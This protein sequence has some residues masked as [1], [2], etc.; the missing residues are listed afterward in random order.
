[1]K[2]NG[3][4]VVTLVFWV[5]LVSSPYNAEG[6]FFCFSRLTD[7]EDKIAALQS[8]CPGGA[9]N[10]SQHRSSVQGN[11]LLFF[12]VYFGCRSD[13]SDCR[14]ELRNFKCNTTKAPINPPISAPMNPPVSAPTNKDSPIA[15]V[16]PLAA[17]ITPPATTPVIAPLAAPVKAPAI[18]PVKPP[19]GAPVK[20]DICGGVCYPRDEL[21]VFSECCCSKECYYFLFYSLCR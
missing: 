14:A 3:G 16:A 10:S 19:V 11:T 12:L 5:I 15:P 18:A 17:P 1:M 21:C 4:A 2:L 7:C 9:L 13:L 20:V 6:F 8:A